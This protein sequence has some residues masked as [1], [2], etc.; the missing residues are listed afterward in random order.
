M[1]Q[2]IREIACLDSYP[3]LILNNIKQHAIYRDYLDV[4]YEHA[5]EAKVFK[6][7]INPHSAIWIF[8]DAHLAVWHSLSLS[9]DGREEH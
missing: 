8:S 9:V 5:K 4:R 3:H 1:L 6:K 2:N 7:K